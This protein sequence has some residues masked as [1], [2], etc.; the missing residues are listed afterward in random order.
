VKAGDRIGVLVVLELL[1]GGEAGHPGRGTC[2]KCRCPAGH[3]VVVRASKSRRSA[4]CPECRAARGEHFIA[5]RWPGGW[6]GIPREDTSR[7]YGVGS[8]LPGA[9]E[10]LPVR[11]AVVTRKGRTEHDTFDEAIVEYR[12]G[13]GWPA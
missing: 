9:S 3:V 2:A 11:Y 7:R 10:D 1:T 13:M 4:T 5:K 6:R 8:V 12:I